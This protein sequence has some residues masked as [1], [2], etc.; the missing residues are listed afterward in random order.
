MRIDISDYIYHCIHN[1]EIYVFPFLHCIVSILFITLLL[2]S[3]KRTSEVTL[4]DLASFV[5]RRRRSRLA[6]TEKYA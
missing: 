3:R 1:S 4:F 5:F 6:Q 2:R